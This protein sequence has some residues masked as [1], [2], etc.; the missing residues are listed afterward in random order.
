MSAVHR[1]ATLVQFATFGALWIFQVYH[2]S[3]WWGAIGTFIG[4]GAFVLGL[5]LPFIYLFKTGI[6]SYTLFGL[7]CGFIAGTIVAARTDK[8]G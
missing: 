6:F 5:A 4:M 2:W 3:Q 1:I 7:L 8:G